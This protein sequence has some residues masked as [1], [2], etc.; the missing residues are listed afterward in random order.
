MDSFRGVA[1]ALEREA[2][3]SYK[4]ELALALDALR[5]APNVKWAKIFFDSMPA[6]M[7]SD[8]R[9]LAH[10]AIGLQ[11]EADKCKRV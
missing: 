10:A 3:L 2:M 5:A 1:D 8:L 6:R 4:E 9:R 11:S 7:Q